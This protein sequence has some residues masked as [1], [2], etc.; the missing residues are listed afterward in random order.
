MFDPASRRPAVRNL[1]QHFHLGLAEPA[2]RLRS[3]LLG[4]DGADT[5]APLEMSGVAAGDEAGEGADRGQ[6]L[7]AGLRGAAAVIHRDGRGTAEYAGP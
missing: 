5:C 6:A 7:I 3:C 4:G 2:D 1:E